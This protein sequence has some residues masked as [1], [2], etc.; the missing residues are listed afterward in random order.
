MRP[1][2][3]R[4]STFV[5]E[6]LCDDAIWTGGRL[7]CASSVADMLIGM[8]SRDGA[9]SSWCHEVIGEITHISLSAHRASPVMVSLALEGSG[10]TAALDYARMT[11][12]ERCLADIED[13]AC[14][15]GG[16]DNETRRDISARL[17]KW[18]ESKGDN[19]VSSPLVHVADGEHA[20]ADASACALDAL[21]ALAAVRRRHPDALDRCD[22]KRV[23]SPV[24]DRYAYEAA[25]DGDL[26]LLDRVFAL[27]GSTRSGGS[28]PETARFPDVH[29]DD[30]DDE[31]VGD[32]IDNDDHRESGDSTTAAAAAAADYSVPYHLIN[33]VRTRSVRSRFARG[34]TAESYWVNHAVS[35]AIAGDRADALN[36]IIE[37]AGWICIMWAVK[38]AIKADCAALFCVAD[39]RGL[40]Y[41]AHGVLRSAVRSGGPRVCAHMVAVLQRT[42][43]HIEPPL[44]SLIDFP[45]S[46]RIWGWA[47]NMG[48]TPDARWFGAI[49]HRHNV[50]TVGPWLAAT[51]YMMRIEPMARL[52]VVWPAEAM[53]HLGALAVAAAALSTQDECDGLAL[54][55]IALERDQCDV[56]L[57]AVGE[58][59]V[60]KSAN[61]PDV[62][63]LFFALHWLARMAHYCEPE[64]VRV[65]PHTHQID[66]MLE[67]EHQRSQNK[68]HPQTNGAIDWSR[69]CRPR[70]LDGALVSCVHTALARRPNTLADRVYAR[71]ARDVLAHLRNVLPQARRV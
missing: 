51:Q 62:C 45:S 4:C 19:Y 34:K 67:I 3:P 1:M 71:R 68:G 47:R 48:F 58:S 27:G 2:P 24:F 20:P 29:Y 56:D 43:G 41:D 35:G 66:K 65:A 11:L 23:L 8:S 52:A 5:K 12:D 63:R 22:H 30:G 6:S 18:I 59:D 53:K 21:R 31:H 49:V 42:Q 46:T 39:A 14:N 38:R 7:L 13:A 40:T 28:C 33:Q 17:S 54:L 10:V 25:F 32:S 60:H 70:P 16:T 37:R 57:W 44:D 9:E 61:G 36:F 55:L 15:H 64:R 26:D 50:H 69:F